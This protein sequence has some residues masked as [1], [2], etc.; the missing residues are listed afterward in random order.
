MANIMQLPYSHYILVAIGTG[1]PS[2]IATEGVA[3][4]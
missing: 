3:D 1:E 2:E 4:A